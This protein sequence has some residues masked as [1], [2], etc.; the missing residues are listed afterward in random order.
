[1]GT[2]KRKLWVCF[3]QGC[4]VCKGKGVS[5]DVPDDCQVS[6][7]HAL[8]MRDTGLQE[9]PRRSGK[10]HT[11]AEYAAKMMD[12][13]APVLVVCSTHAMKEYFE[14]LMRV[15]F[16]ERCPVETKYTFAYWIKGQEGKNFCVFTDE[17]NPKE[18][19]DLKLDELGH[20]FV[21]GFYTEV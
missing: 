16:G 2:P 6:I 3:E 5:S 4:R 19:E 21:L 8:D 17:L 10:T 9:R 14:K 20:E 12:A 11:I 1:M 18:V 13:G 7:L 15:R